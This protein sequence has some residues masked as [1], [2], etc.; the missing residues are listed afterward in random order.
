[1]QSKVQ[2]KMEDQGNTVEILQNIQT[3]CGCDV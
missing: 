2:D 1:M 3:R